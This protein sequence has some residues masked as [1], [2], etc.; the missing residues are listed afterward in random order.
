MIPRVPDIV[1]EDGGPYYK[2]TDLFQTYLYQYARALA[3]AV[4]YIGGQHQ[5]RDHVGDPQ[6]RMPF[7]PVSKE[8]QQEALDMITENAFSPDAVKLPKEVYQKM[9]ADRWSHWGY[10]N[11]YSGRVDYPLHQT[12]VGIQSALLEQL[13]DPVRLQ[14]IRDT[15]VKFG[16]EK[17]LTIPELMNQITASVWNEIWSSPGTNILSNRRD[18]QRAYLSQMVGLLTDAPEEAPADARSVARHALTKLNET[19]AAR[20][21]TPSYDFDAYTKA[22]LEESGAMITKALDASLIHEN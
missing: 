4:K 20:L 2:A 8:K 9:G 10:S 6:G 11:T 17:T 5:Y 12:L 18:L 14:R 3:P 19:I 1:L 22:H 13:L 7:V 16:A 15:E 21:K